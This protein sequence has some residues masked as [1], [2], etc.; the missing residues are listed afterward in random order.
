MDANDYPLCWWPILRFLPGTLSLAGRCRLQEG[1]ANAA[2][3]IRAVQGGLGWMIGV[4]KC[5]NLW[6]FWYSKIGAF[7]PNL[8]VFFTK[9]WIRIVK[10]PGWTVVKLEVK[11]SGTWVEICWDPPP[12]FLSAYQRLYCAVLSSVYC[13]C[14]TCHVPGA[15]FHHL[16]MWSASLWRWSQETF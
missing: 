13:A 3:G 8:N 16:L 1:P 5:G 11:F 12:R 4:A 2:L 14:Y 9:F 10:V 6:S 7:L 15:R